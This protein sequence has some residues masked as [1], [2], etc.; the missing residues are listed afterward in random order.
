MTMRMIFLVILFLFSCDD[1]RSEERQNPLPDGTELDV[2]VIGS[3]FMAFEGANTADFIKQ[4][5]D[6]AGYTLRLTKRV[7]GGYRLSNH[8]ATPIVQEL[9]RDPKFDLIVLQGSGQFM[10]RPEWHDQTMPY[11]KQFIDEIRDSRSTAHI[12][13]LMPWA[14][15]DGLQNLSGYTEDFAAMQEN[16]R[17]YTVETIHNF[18]ISTAPAGWTWYQLKLNGYRGNL[19]HPDRNHQSIDGAYA[20]ACAVFAALYD[21][22][23]PLL[24]LTFSE[25]SQ[26]D[27]IRHQ[28]L[29]V[30]QS[31]HREWNL[32]R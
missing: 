25:D 32:Y 31:S 22:L 7:V 23:P 9:I 30:R 5:A 14:H 2:L 18:G 4:L 13:Y 29:R 16:I 15:Q 10:S 17:H 3:S 11:L 1:N 27:S 12:M 21:E 6:S 8:I 24:P 28:A 26:P 19:H 20:A